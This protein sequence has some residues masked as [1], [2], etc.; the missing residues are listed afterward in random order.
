MDACKSLI[1][2]DSIKCDRQIDGH[3]VL[4]RTSGYNTYTYS[5]TRTYYNMVFSDV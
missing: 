3:V 4:V 5:H 1:I 2:H